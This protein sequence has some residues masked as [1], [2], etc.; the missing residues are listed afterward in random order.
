MAVWVLAGGWEVGRPRSGAQPPPL[1]GV[2][3]VILGGVIMPLGELSCKCSSS[4]T[5]VH[6]F[7]GKKRIAYLCEDCARHSPTLR[8]FLQALSWFYDWQQLTFAFVHAGV[9]S[10]GFR[11]YLDAVIRQEGERVRFLREDR[12]A[13]RMAWA[14]G[15][16][17]RETP[18][19]GA[20]AVGD[21]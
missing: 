10:E 6:V 9:T 8:S 4:K 1:C 19:V 11:T 14:A 20:L 7:V 15:A 17:S 2:T 16:S 21:D 13:R 12:L 18:W 3:R 5:V